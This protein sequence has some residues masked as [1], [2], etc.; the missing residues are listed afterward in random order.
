MPAATPGEYRGLVVRLGPG[1]DGRWYV[2]VGG[3][4]TAAAIPLAPATFV[5]RLWRIAATGELR[6]TIRLAGDEH[7]APLRSNAEL[8]GLVRAWLLPTSPRS[9]T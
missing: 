1:A 3:T 6:G 4:S 5:V 2:D 7:T 8:E 9:A